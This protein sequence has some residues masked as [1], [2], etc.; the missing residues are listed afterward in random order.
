AALDGGDELR[1]VHFERVEDVVRVILGTKTYLALAGASLLDDL[2]G[3]MLGLA[4]DL[5]LG[6]QAGLFLAR[7]ADD[8]LGLA[9]GL[10]QHL[11]ALLH[12]PARLLDLLGDRGA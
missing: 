9:L 4:H 2:L 8:P 10:G 6:D 5:L 12:N 3:L 7:L 1:E 11:L